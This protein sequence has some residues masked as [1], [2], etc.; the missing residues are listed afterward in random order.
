MERAICFP[1]LKE[2]LKR[3]LFFFHLAKIMGFVRPEC[4]LKTS[5]GKMPCPWEGD[6]LNFNI[7]LMWL[8]EKEYMEGR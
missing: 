8:E 6:N 5:K 7:I 2:V 1:Y 4:M 3:K